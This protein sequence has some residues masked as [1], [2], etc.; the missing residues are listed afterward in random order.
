MYDRIKSCLTKENYMN[1]EKLP[2][3]LEILEH[4]KWNFCDGVLDDYDYTDEKLKKIYEEIVYRIAD[5][6]QD[7]KVQDRIYEAKYRWSIMKFKPSFSQKCLY[8][9][10]YF[11]RP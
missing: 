2:Y 8:Q 9:E 6:N 4:L 5:L 10:M 7:Y 11:R 3:A 1:P